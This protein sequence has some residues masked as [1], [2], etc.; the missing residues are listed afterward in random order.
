MSKTESSIVSDNELYSFNKS[1]SGSCHTLYDLAN[2]KNGLAFKN[3]D[4]SP[5]GKPVIKIAELNDGIGPTTAYTEKEYPKEVYL[6]KGDFLFSWSGNPQTSIDIYK[7]QMQEGWLNQHI[8]KVIPN[9][10]LIH[11]D[12]FFYLMKAL[13]PNFTKI[14]TNKQTTGL[15]HVTIADLK[16]LE[17]T[18]PDY[19]KQKKIAQI[20][21]SL[22]EKIEL[23][24]AI[25]RNLEEQTQAIFNSWFVDF[26]PFGG[27]MPED[28]QIG[29]LSDIAEYEKDKI[30]V[31]KLNA[32]TYYSTENMLP[33]KAGVSKAASLPT[34]E[35][36][37][38]CI[39][40]ETIISNIRPYF[41]KIFYCSE[42]TAGCSADVLCFKPKK[43]SFSIYNYGLLYSD[44]FFDYM[45][46]GSKG[47]KMPR[48][49]KSQIM[50][51][52]VVIP[53]E[54]V[55]SDF[56]NVV[57]NILQQISNNKKE[58]EC[59]AKLRDTLL[60]DLMSGELCLNT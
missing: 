9:E 26:E 14:A 24:N 38:R 4:F 46:K 56:N 54:S 59:L 37:T 49:D 1:G 21:L 23:N 6:Q 30:D 48:G 43:E 40:G 39:P 28:W 35:Q 16:R 51:Y 8:F 32:E 53:A 5:T 3:I 13:K 22:D 20:L 44:K 47:T 42:E 25:N 50:N 15:G 57:S 41:K 60:P 34:T 31:A 29:K 2:W 55:I 19:N 17:V 11:R 12:F 10:K 7:F 52:D 58:N 27:K 36:T 18:I 45:V 33:N